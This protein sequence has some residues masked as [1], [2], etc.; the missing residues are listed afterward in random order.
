MVR[1]T[2]N[3][4][5]FTLVCCVAAVFCACGGDEAAPTEVTQPEV[6]EEDRDSPDTPQMCTGC[7]DDD[8]EC[9][10]GGADDSCGSGG[11]SCQACDAG[12]TCN[13]G[14]CEA[15]ATPGECTPESCDGCCMMGECMAGDTNDACGGGGLGCLSCRE[16]TMC[17]EGSCVE[18]IP[19]ACGPNNCAGCCDPSG[20]CAPGD[21]RA[22][23]GLGGGACV[24]C[25]DT[26][27]MCGGDGTCAAP[28]SCAATCAGCCDGET[29]VMAPTEAQCG[30]AGNACMACGAGE[31][32]NAGVC[33]TPMIVQNGYWDLYLVSATIPPSKPNGSSWDSFGGDPDP[34]LYAYTEDTDFYW[35]ETSQIFFDEYNPVWNEL[36]LIAVSDEALMMGIELEFIDDEGFPDSICY[37]FAQVPDPSLLTGGNIDTTCPDDPRMTFT[38]RL[39][40]SATPP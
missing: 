16:P 19:E 6:R 2:T 13:A 38:W 35:E 17:H 36:I 31:V 24:D 11:A 4:V 20:A 26:G 29:C 32:C 1:S 5:L 21:T 8:G 23:C 9:Q 7:V 18:E 22:A 12:E 10:S 3:S 27:E 37:V 28:T 25:N 34:Y 30:M 39:E 14:S 33:E 15:D 40:P